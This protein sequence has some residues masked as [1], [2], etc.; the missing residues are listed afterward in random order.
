MH[1]GG[2]VQLSARNGVKRVI[3]QGGLAGTRHT[4]DAGHETEGNCQVDL[5]EIVAPGPVKT[6][7]LFRVCRAPLDRN[8]DLPFSRKELTCYGP[9]AADNVRKRAAHEHFA[10]MDARSRADIDDVVGG[11]DRLLVVFDD[12]NGITQIT[13]VQQRIE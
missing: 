13:K 4:C 1:V 2:A 8:L 3:D 7:R 5:L 6:K 11:A 10:A 12:D 9:R